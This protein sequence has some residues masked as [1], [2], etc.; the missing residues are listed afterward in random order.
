MSMNIT[1]P[2]HQQARENARRF[3]ADIFGRG[4]EY[5]RCQACLTIEDAAR[6]AGM[7]LSE[8]MAMEAGGF[9]PQSTGQLQAIAGTLEMDYE[10]L[11]NLVLLCWSAW[12]G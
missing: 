1:H 6:L 11:I 9:Q 2:N 7:Q 10:R 5:A 8:W 3:W 4:I 12:E